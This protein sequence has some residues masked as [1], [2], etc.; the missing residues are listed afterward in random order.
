MPKLI[1]YGGVNEVSESR[2]LLEDQETE[3]YLDMGKNFSQRHTSGLVAADQTVEGSLPPFPNRG[4]NNIP[5]Q[6]VKGRLLDCPQQPK[7]LRQHILTRG[8]FSL[9]LLGEIEVIKF[10]QICPARLVGR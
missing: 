5:K 9:Y 10:T 3:V 6:H 8:S 2:V 1:F 4:Q 7:S